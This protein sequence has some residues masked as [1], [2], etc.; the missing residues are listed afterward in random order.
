MG[1]AVIVIANDFTA[2]SVAF[3][4]PGEHASAQL[5]LPDI[6]FL[7]LLVA[8][9][10]RFRLRTGWTWVATTLSFGATMAAAVWLGV[11]GLPALPLLSAAFV[12]VNA[13]LLWRAS[14]A[15]RA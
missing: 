8:A 6:L 10:E 5:G 1:V 14:R 11:A 15:R 9:A 4:I 13:D 3:P 12:L 7:A 2:L